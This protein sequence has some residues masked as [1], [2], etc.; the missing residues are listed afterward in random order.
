MAH[1]VYLWLSGRVS[2]NR[3]SGPRR[4]TVLVGLVGLVYVWQLLSS[5]RDSGAGTGW[6]SRASGRYVD[7]GEIPR[8]DRAALDKLRLLALHLGGDDDDD[9]EGDD[10]EGR[11]DSVEFPADSPV[12][13]AVKYAQV[14]PTR[15][16]APPLVAEM[17]SVLKPDP[18]A[19]VVN[20]KV[21]AHILDA[22]VCP[23]REGEPCSFLVPAWLGEP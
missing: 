1:D 15:D 11:P 12:V 14:P 20:D 19:P 17:P 7:D 6:I 4:W 18:M 22:E 8:V 13:G 9:D 23:E 5:D 10:N 16:D 2:N 3:R 21:P